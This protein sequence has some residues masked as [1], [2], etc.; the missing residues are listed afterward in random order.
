MAITRVAVIGCGR[1]F[2][3]VIAPALAAWGVGA[4]LVVD[5]DPQARDR[6]ARYLG[7]RRV[8]CQE[9]LTAGA[10][11]DANPDG[12]IIASPSGLHFDQVRISLAC[13]LPTFVEKPAS[14][15]ADAL[16]SLY[17]RGGNLL[18]AAEQRI[19]RRD[20]NLA[21][22]LIKSG[23][24]GHVKRIVYH[25]T[26]APSPEFEYSWRNRPE[27]ASGGILL[28]LGYHTVGAIQWLLDQDSDHFA[29]HSAR[30]A[31]GDLRVE[32]RAAVACAWDGTEIELDLALDSL[33]PR[34]SLAVTGSLGR[35]IIERR[36]SAGDVSSFLLETPDHIF[37]QTIPLGQEYDVK[38][39]SDFIFQVRSPQEKRLD[40]H[41]TTLELIGK[42]YQSADGQ[43]S[44]LLSCI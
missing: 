36:R 24:L 11:A 22:S 33:Q 7:R 3:S 30:L 8:V 18:Y 12:V 16:K 14:C 43:A 10:L 21:R 20:L 28:D 17:D 6:A 42:M 9:T 31:H 26:I 34:E 1:R 2:T 44:E 23:S 19:H 29:V 15:T 41:I 35:I 5:P 32:S 38:S 27:L 37:R 39:L 25:D 13:G 40:G 4:V